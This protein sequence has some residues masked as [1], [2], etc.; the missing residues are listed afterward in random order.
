MLRSLVGSEMCIRDRPWVV[1]PRDQLCFRSSAGFVI[2]DV[3]L[4]AGMLPVMAVLLIQLLADQA[5][6]L[7]LP[8]QVSAVL[9]L[10][11]LA[12]GILGA[13]SQPGIVQPGHRIDLRYSTGF[14]AVLRSLQLLSLTLALAPAPGHDFRHVSFVVTTALL[15]VL[16]CSPSLGST[17]LFVR[18]LRISSAAA[19]LLFA[20]VNSGSLWGWARPD[21]EYCALGFAAVLLLGM[22]IAG[23]VHSS[24]RRENLEKMGESGL[25][26]ALLALRS[27]RGRLVVSHACT[28]K[29]PT[30]ENIGSA[31]ELALSLV[32]FEEA[33]VVDRMSLEF[34][35]QREQWLTQLRHSVDDYTQLAQLASAL[36]RHIQYPRMFSE[37]L[38]AL[39]TWHVDADHLPYDLCIM[40]LHHVLD[41]ERLKVCMPILDVVP[42]RVHSH[43]QSGLSSLISFQ[44][45]QSTEFLR[46]MGQDT[47]NKPFPSGTGSLI[48]EIDLG[49]VDAP[50]SEYPGH[51]EFQDRRIPIGA[52]RPDGTKILY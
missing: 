16:E 1:A 19:L 6:D 20:L 45:R 3:L 52:W 22:A 26:E 39:R 15:L 42:S 36:H 23:K 32:D 40:I 14:A 4:K 5:V 51:T 47:N 18:P 48:G 49:L 8:L 31:Q 50:E 28:N 7:I 13:N 35:L 41:L 29:L 27:L 24:W 11:V 25:P 33:V 2:W 46:A 34:L 30:V 21:L 9:L 38:W 37:L 10:C 12:I 43:N 17:V 44:W